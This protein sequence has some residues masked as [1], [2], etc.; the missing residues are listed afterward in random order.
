MEYYTGNNT[1]KQK[2]PDTN[3]LIYIKSKTAESTY[4]GRYQGGEDLLLVGGG[5]GG[6]QEQG[7]WDTGMVCFLI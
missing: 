3:E 5:A 1:N 4:A 2:A 7:S 6:G